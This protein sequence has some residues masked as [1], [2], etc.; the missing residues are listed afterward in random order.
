MLERS[1]QEV[2]ERRHGV[3][4]HFELDQDFGKEDVNAVLDL[5]LTIMEVFVEHLERSQG[6]HIRDP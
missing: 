1:L 4:H 5:I 6:R 2:I 3:V